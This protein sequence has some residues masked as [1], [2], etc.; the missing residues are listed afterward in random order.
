VKTRSL[1]TC[2][3]RQLTDFFREL[4]ISVWLNTISASF[5]HHVSMEAD[6]TSELLRCFRNIRAY[7][8]PK[9]CDSDSSI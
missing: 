5:L 7:K 6:P 2:A 8:K 9:R 1:Y 4:V 3:Y